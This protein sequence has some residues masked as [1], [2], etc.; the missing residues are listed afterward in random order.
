ME[1]FRNNI[2]NHQRELK[3]P[4]NN[5][6]I[7]SNPNRVIFNNYK[8][9]K[10]YGQQDF[11]IDDKDLNNIIDEYISNNSLGGKPVHT[12]CTLCT[13]CTLFKKFQTTENTT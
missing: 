12:T 11:K 13:L 10:T 8:T 9:Y 1:I 3:D 5:Y 4:I 7:L 2:K 6:L